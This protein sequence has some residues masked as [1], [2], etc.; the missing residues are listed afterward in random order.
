MKRRERRNRRVRSRCAVGRTNYLFLFI[1]LSVGFIFDG[2]GGEGSSFEELAPVNDSKQPNINRG[3]QIV[4]EY[5]KRDF[6]AFRKSR[7]KLTVEPEEGRKK[8]Y[9]LDILRKQIEGETRSLTNIVEPREDRDL[10]TLTIEKTGRETVNINYIAS[11]A[12]FRESS[13]RKMFFGGLTSQELLG[14]WGKY[15]SRFLA[16]KE[17]DG[18]RVFEVESILKTDAKSVIK[19]IVTLFGAD[20]YLP[21]E[22]HLF[23]S[24][25]R[26]IRT[27]YI[28]ETRRVGNKKIV[29]KTLIKNH[30]YKAQV[31]IEVLDMSFPD[32]ISADV[33]KRAHL[34]TFANR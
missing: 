21:R 10:A 2:C 6:V 17:R 26:E 33:F 31:T 23:N 32:S 4:I 12:K 5:L 14:E 7:I 3:E 8:V 20:D 11:R 1:L 27:F 30:I 9:I 22:L 24:D 28:K 25:D 29:S 19:R 34:K 16:E 13:T 15:K 18:S